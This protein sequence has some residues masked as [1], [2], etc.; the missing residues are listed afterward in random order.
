MPPV[1]DINEPP[2]IVD[3]NGTHPVPDSDVDSDLSRKKILECAAGKILGIC[4]GDWVD[5]DPGAIAADP[6]WGWSFQCVGFDT[7]N[8]IDYVMCLVKDPNSGY[9]SAQAFSPPLITS[10]FRHT[11]EEVMP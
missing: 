5:I 7:V 9:Y 4:P 3:E 1:F 2:S 11:P 6:D 10:N 8:N